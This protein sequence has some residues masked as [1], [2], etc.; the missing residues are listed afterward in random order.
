M[1]KTF[2]RNMWVMRRITAEQV[3]AYVSKYISQEQ[4]DEILATEQI[5]VEG[6]EE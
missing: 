2:I 4:A 3:Q 1:V 5:Q 6:A